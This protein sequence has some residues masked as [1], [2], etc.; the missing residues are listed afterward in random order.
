MMVSK[1]K[2]HISM[3]YCIQPFIIKVKLRFHWLVS[4][5]IFHMVNFMQEKFFSSCKWLHTNPTMEFTRLLLIL[6]QFWMEFTCLLLLLCQFW[7]GSRWDCFP[8]LDMSFLVLLELFQLNKLLLTL[9]TNRDRAKFH[10]SRQFFN[11]LLQSMTAGTFETTRPLVTLKWILSSEWLFA[12]CT[13]MVCIFM[14]SFVMT[15][16][17]INP[18]K[19]SIANGAHVFSIHVDQLLLAN[20]GFDWGGFFIY[21]YIGWWCGSVKIVVSYTN[22][23]RW[24]AEVELTPPPQPWTPKH[25]HILLLNHDEYDAGHG[26]HYCSKP[27]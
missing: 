13:R 27:G 16:Q 23:A 12:F 4:C 18:T 11:V 15:S 5:C 19:T 10:M 1:D 25:L 2:S 24:W 7:M 3:K 21:I 22:R 6:R 20:W 9:F 8:F 17:G 26:T 14:L